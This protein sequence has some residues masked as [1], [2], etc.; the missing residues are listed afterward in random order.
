[1]LTYKR[2]LIMIAV[3][4]LKDNSYG[5]HVACLIMNTTGRHSTLKTG[6]YVML[7]RLCEMGYLE[8]WI[9]TERNPHDKRLREGRPFYSVT[10]EGRKE[11]S[12]TFSEFDAMR[13]VTAQIFEA[14]KA[15]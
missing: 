12:R 5:S 8:R 1:M 15:A 3:E 4:I 13:K 10:R 6:V 2:I 7:Q 11:L 9:N 14:R